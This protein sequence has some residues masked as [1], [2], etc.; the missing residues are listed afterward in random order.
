MMGVIAAVAG[1]IQIASWVIALLDA[2]EKPP[3]PPP[4]KARHREP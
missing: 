3:V 2:I 1:A 4:S